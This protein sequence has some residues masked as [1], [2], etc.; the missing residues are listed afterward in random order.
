V[1]VSDQRDQLGWVIALR[2]AVGPREALE[3]EG[4]ALE[5]LLAG[6]RQ[7][8]IDLTGVTEVRPGLIAALLRIRRGLAHIGAEMTVLAEG[9]PAAEAT[10]SAGLGTAGRFSRSMGPPVTRE[11]FPRS[12]APPGPPRRFSR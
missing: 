3:L 12:T 10:L 9:S 2:G 4:C 1:A 7:I 6:H 11:R 8:T 5:A